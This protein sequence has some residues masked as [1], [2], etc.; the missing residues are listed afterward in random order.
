MESAY[1][2]FFTTGGACDRE[3]AIWTHGA[4][5]SVVR[6]AELT[7]SADSTSSRLVR[8]RA[9]AKQVAQGDF[10]L[11]ASIAS[12]TVPVFYNR[13]QIL[14]RDSAVVFT[15]DVIILPAVVCE[16]HGARRQFRLSPFCFCL[17]PAVVPG[18]VLLSGVPGPLAVEF[19]V[20]STRTKAIKRQLH[21]LFDHF[22]GVAAVA[23]TVVQTRALFLAAG[24]RLLHL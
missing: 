15:P 2:A 4:R 11:F 14:C 20:L 12:V 19:E 18:A 24:N 22:D 6:V 3:L 17:I 23:E 5:T 7:S 21:Q 1:A 16:K 8:G 10:A 13:Q 9:G